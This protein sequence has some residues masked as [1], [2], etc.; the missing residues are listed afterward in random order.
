MPGFKLYTPIMG[1]I[2]PKTLTRLGINDN[3]ARS[4]A[5]STIAKYSKHDTQQQILSTL[6]DI[7]LHPEDSRNDNIW[8]QLASVLSQ[9]SHRL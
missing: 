4:I 7:V 2:Q 8:G 6:E 5:M 3:M 1:N 9:G